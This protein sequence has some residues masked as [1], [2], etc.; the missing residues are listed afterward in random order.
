MKK[1]TVTWQQ[2]RDAVNEAFEII[3][4]NFV[5]S[6]NDYGPTHNDSQVPPAEPVACGCWPLKRGQQPEV[7]H[8]GEPDGFITR[9]KSRYT[10]SC[11]RPLA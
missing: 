8:D 3:F 5:K 9:E 2:I 6:A 4:K 7:L 1:H 10:P 11:T